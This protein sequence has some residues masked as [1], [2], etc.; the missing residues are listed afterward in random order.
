MSER[1]AALAGSHVAV[2]R[3]LDYLDRD[4]TAAARLELR[5]EERRL[6]RLIAMR[7]PATQGDGRHAVAEGSPDPSSRLKE[8]LTAVTPAPTFSQTPRG[9]GVEPT[10]IPTAGDPS[11]TL[12]LRADFQWKPS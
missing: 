9:T 7:I 8:V 6:R 5:I 12:S 11:V 3:A 2:T 4:D 10:R 1:K